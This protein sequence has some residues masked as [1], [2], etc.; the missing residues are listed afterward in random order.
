MK[1]IRSCI[2]NDSP[3][4]E[5][6]LL[7]LAPY[8]AQLQGLVVESTFNWYW[9]VDGL[10]DAGYLVHLANTTAIQQYTGLKYTDDDTDARWLAHLL[11]L[12]VLP[13]GYIYP[14]AERAVRDLLR[15]RSQL[16]QQKT[17]NLLSIQSSLT[18]NT[19]QVFSG[20]PIKQLLPE[21]IGELV[22]LPEHVVALQATLAVM[23]HLAEQITL[24]ERAVE[25]GKRG[26][27][28]G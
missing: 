19:G 20:N 2:A 12:G 25:K 5:H 17:A 16:V 9:L 4:L 6:I 8:R 13:T 15:K 27:I 26:Q 28:F 24:I 21:T 1:R 10:M 7:Q 14:K 23:R 22:A 3:D 11:R 18:R